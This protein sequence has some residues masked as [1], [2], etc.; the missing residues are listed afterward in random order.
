MQALSTVLKTNLSYLFVA[1]GAIWL[2]FTVVTGSTLLLWPVLACVVSG[3]LLRVAPS[4]N[5]TAAWVGASA[6]MGLVLSAYQAYVA[7]SL[8]MGQL[9]EIAWLSLAA[10]VVFGLVHLY[11][12]VASRSK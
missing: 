2:G 5:F 7:S 4:A 11:L 3:I 6:L 8:L 1:V 12:L 10:F 9:A